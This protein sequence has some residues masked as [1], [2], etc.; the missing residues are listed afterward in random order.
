MLV[1]IRQNQTNADLWDVVALSG[2]FYGQTIA[3]VEGVRLAHARMQEYSITGHISAV[4]GAVF[5]DSYMANSSELLLGVRTFRECHR[6]ASFDTNNS[7]W[8]DSDSRETLRECRYVTAMGPNIFYSTDADIQADREMYDIPD[9][10]APRGL[11]ESIS[12]PPP[13]TRT[14][15]KIFRRIKEAIT[16]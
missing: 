16:A 4:Y 15:G 6:R 13:Q 3:T 8:F 5:S 14:V 2:D 1:R 7:G 11:S 10:P 9:M 12:A